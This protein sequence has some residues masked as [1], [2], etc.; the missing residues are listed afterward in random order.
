MLRHGVD[1]LAQVTLA[2]GG[3]TLCVIYHLTSST[4][5]T[6]VEWC[7]TQSSGPPQPLQ[8]FVL[9]HHLHA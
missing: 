1:C 4:Q 6:G 8:V 2:K 7:S 3:V 5:V 9:A